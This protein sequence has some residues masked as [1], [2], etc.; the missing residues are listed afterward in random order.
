MKDSVDKVSYLVC[1]E[2]TCDCV[3]WSRKCC[4]CIDIPQKYWSVQPCWGHL[5]L[6]FSIRQGFHVILKTC[7]MCCLQENIST[8]IWI[9]EVPLT[10][11][12]VHPHD[13]TWITPISRVYQNVTTVNSFYTYIQY[14]DKIPYNN[15]LNET[16]S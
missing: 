8:Y 12:S 16:N 4:Q 3:V 9:S 2:L 5:F 15:I 6:V 10:C 13:M 7:K 1:Y 11:I 14:D